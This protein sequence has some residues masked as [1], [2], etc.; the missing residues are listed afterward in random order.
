MAANG[1]PEGKNVSEKTDVKDIP[2][3]DSREESVGDVE[4][5]GDY[6]SGRDHAFSDPKVA[7]YWRNVYEK[8]HY[9][10]R[11]RFD[12]TFTWTAQEEIRVK[13]KVSHFG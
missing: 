2:S 3:S 5:Q 10:G 11:H 4:I 12:P 6:G 8:A 9:E 1:P 13:R 7:D